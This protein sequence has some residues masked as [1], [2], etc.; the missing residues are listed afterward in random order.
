MLSNEEFEAWCQSNNFSE[1]TIE[2][3]SKIRCAAPVR[4][5][6]GGNINVPGKYSSQKMG[7]A[8]QFES[9]T[10]ELAGVME[11]EFSDSVLEYYDQPFTL[12]LDYIKHTGKRIVIYNTPD[13]F[14]IKP[15]FAG[16]IEFKPEQRLVELSSKDPVRYCKDE[17]G[18]WRHPPAEIAAQKLGLSYKI[19]TDA[20]T[21]PTLIANLKF[22]EDYFLN[23]NAVI[24]QVN[25]EIILG[26][27]NEKKGILLSE[28]IL[29][30]DLQEVKIDDFY[31]LLVQGK[32]YV[33]LEKYLLG[34]PQNVPVYE[35]ALIAES[36]T[37]ATN[38][39][40]NSGFHTYNFFRPKLNQ[41]LIWD[42]TPVTVLNIGEK[43]IALKNDDN[44]VT[45]SH[46][47]FITLVEGGKI[48]GLSLEEPKGM[49]PEVTS[50]MESASLNDMERA[51]RRLKMIQPIIEGQ[52]TDVPLKNSRTIRDWIRKYKDAEQTLGNGYV[53][54]IDN[55][56]NKGNRS[57]RIPSETLELMDSFIEKYLDNRQPNR[58]AV[59]GQFAKT[60][61]EKKLN[62][63][64]SYQTFCSEIKKRPI[65]ERTIKRQGKKAAQQFD[66]F[67]IYDKRGSN[68]GERPY[69]IAHVD[70][71]EL[72]IE[73]VDSITFKPLGRAWLSVLTDAFSREVLAHY[74]SFDPPSYRSTMMV[75]RECVRRHNRL[76]KTFVV[77][78]G[79]EF[80]SCYFEKT[81]SYFNRHKK[82]R[83]GRP[84]KGTVI[85]R[86]FG[87]VNT[88]LIY[89]LLGNT[90]MTKK[91]R[92]M[93]KTTNPKK[94]AIWN[95][96]DFNEKLSVFL[97][98]IYNHREHPAHGM[99]P[100]QQRA[101][102]IKNSGERLQETIRYDRTFLIQTMPSSKKGKAK[103]QPGRG[104]SNLY[105]YYW[106][107]EFRDGKIE[108]TQVNIRY[109]P[110][111]LGL[112]YAYVNNR[113]VECRSENFWAFEGRTEKE[114]AIAMSEYRK[115]NSISKKNYYIRVQEFA[116][117]IESCQ[118]HEVALQKNRDA[119]SKRAY[120]IPED[121]KGIQ[122]SITIVDEMEH[123]AAQKALPSFNAKVS[124]KVDFNKIVT[125]EVR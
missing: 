32:C 14:I 82:V 34:Y 98:D 8:I 114:I 9:H 40:R 99:T 80:H 57:R 91:V 118:S 5:V 2:V 11:M 93:D 38:A 37:L 111:N 125:L 70:H 29:K 17:N 68:H 69:E 18:I 26:I 113:W 12:K 119:E 51:N 13:Y 116:S 115:R 66:E 71:T 46:P 112:A 24:S 90:Q 60:C 45:M 39:S 4:S 122:P 101:I 62:I 28:L 72:D 22:L 3:M 95:L 1:N 106:C 59:Y 16:F 31:L 30:L 86:L 6:A 56:K 49:W 47:Q 55:N 121:K 43:E 81:L 104:F 84:Q 36:F 89:N 7:M 100:H 63:I 85:E 15:K 50:I 92:Q 53:G 54:L 75:I 21:S 52:E 67:I 108:G 48:S 124:K 78:G 105:N 33:N 110:Y 83:T 74:L 44:I 20:D 42:G 94:K 109:D 19:K 120:A 65:R 97:Y 123:R 117:F 107:D 102:G 103:V 61:E 58:A 88:N 77:D 27:V 41:T 87:T 64:P 10:L 76:P 25:Q 23:K 96:T 35:S 73:F 79:K